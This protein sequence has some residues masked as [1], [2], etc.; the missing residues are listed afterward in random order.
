MQTRT[1]VSIFTLVL[2]V[3]IVTSSCTTLLTPPIQRA[4]EK[5]NL[6]RVKKLIEEG[7][8]VNARNFDWWT[9]LMYA[10]E[11]GYTDI[12]K[13]LLEAGADVNARTKLGET[14]LKSTSK[15]K[16]PEIVSLLREAGAKE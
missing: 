7:A 6:P 5:D 11:Y 15:K 3:S 2:A 4:A 16:Y 1:L 10:S 8:N 12:A 9:A 13:L 14:A